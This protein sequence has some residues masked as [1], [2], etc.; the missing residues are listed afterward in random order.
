[1]A[2]KRKGV[3]NHHLIEQLKKKI[4]ESHKLVGKASS[5][6]LQHAL[7]C[8]KAL[9]RIRYETDNWKVEG[10]KKWIPDNFDFSYRTAN[11]YCRIARNWDKPDIVEAR[12][13]GNL[14]SIRS[15][16][17]IIRP[18]KIDEPE[19][20]DFKD[21]NC[22]ISFM[23]SSVKQKFSDA[24][25]DLCKE[26]LEVLES[27]FEI[28]FEGLYDKLYHQ[29]CLK[30]DCDYNEFLL[31][32]GRLDKAL[33]KNDRRKKSRSEQYRDAEKAGRE[34]LKVVNPEKRLQSI[35]DR[36]ERHRKICNRILKSLNKK[37]I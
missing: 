22:R 12:K 20:I 36:Q 13:D 26:E 18:P 7:V 30:M 5:A 34:D 19:P 33:P 35:T 21:K 23:R 32:M 16:L 25:R 24:L 31:E 14:E 29:V 2:K 11:D 4:I 3:N 8:G 27:E 6:A 17:N 1:M 28:F 9:N 15:V 10:W 37:A